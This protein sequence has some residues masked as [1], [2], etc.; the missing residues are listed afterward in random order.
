MGILKVLGMDLA[1]HKREPRPNRVDRSA[2]QKAASLQRRL[3]RRAQDSKAMRYFGNYAG[4]SPKVRSHGPS[5]QE[6]AALVKGFRF[7]R[8]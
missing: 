8:A 6:R 3:A 2:R 5:S 1:R 7:G 4:A